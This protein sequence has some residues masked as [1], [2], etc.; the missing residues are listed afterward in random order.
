MDGAKV[1]STNTG[2]KCVTRYTHNQSFVKYKLLHVD[3][4]T[5]VCVKPLVVHT[6]VNMS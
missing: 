4:G 5:A 2:T 1:G 6:G 3:A